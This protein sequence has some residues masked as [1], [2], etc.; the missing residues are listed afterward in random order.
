MSRL[1]DIDLKRQELNDF[2]SAFGYTEEEFKQAID[3]YL[4]TGKLPAKGAR[5]VAIAVGLAYD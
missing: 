2:A 4:Q 3:N 1:S 5:A